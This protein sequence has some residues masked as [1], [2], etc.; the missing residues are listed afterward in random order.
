MDAKHLAVTRGALS[1]GPCVGRRLYRPGS[2]G[3]RALAPLAHFAQTMPDRYCCLDGRAV[4]EAAN[5]H[6]AHR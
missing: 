4:S 3:G 5:P 2:H 6:M 1:G